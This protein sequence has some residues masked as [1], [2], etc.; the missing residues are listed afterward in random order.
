RVGSARLALAERPR[1]G[2]EYGHERQELACRR[3]GRDLDPHVLAEPRLKERGTVVVGSESCQGRPLEV[4][5]VGSK[6]EKPILRSPRDADE[7]RGQEALAVPV[8]QAVV[9]LQVHARAEA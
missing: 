7:L 9:R 3:S 8:E 6:I 4:F 1:L 2:F 5:V